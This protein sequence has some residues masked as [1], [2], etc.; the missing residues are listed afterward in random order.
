M[1]RLLAIFL[2][3]VL[4]VGYA[5]GEERRVEVRHNEWCSSVYDFP[6]ITLDWSDGSL[7]WSIGYGVKQNG[8]T[9]KE[10]MAPSRLK[11]TTSK[12][13][14]GENIRDAKVVPTGEY[15]SYYIYDSAIVDF[16]DYSVELRVSDDGVAYRFI[17]NIDE[18]FTVVN[19]LAEFSFDANDKA[20]IPYV[21][22][23]P[24]ATSDY[25]TQFETSFEN[26]YSIT[27]L[28][29]IDWRRLIFAPI[30]LE[31]KGLKFWISEANL[32]DYPGMFFSNRDQD[33]TIDTEFAPV[34]DE[35]ERGGYNMLQGMV[36]SRK[37]YIAECKGKRT[38][39]WRVVAIGKEDIDVANNTL[40]WEL[41]DECRIEDT[42]WIKPGKVAW[43]WWNDWGLEGV[44]FKPGINN[45]TYKYYIDFASRYGIEYVILD[46]G[47]SVKG[48]ADLMQVVPEI[49]IAE[50]VA[51]GEERG[52]GIILWA[53]YWALNRDIEGLCKH[54]SEMGVKGWKVDFLD[55]DDQEMVRFVYDLAEI[56][57]KY[58][59]LVD[60]HGVYKPTGL[61]YTYPNA[62]N[63]EGV[64]GLE[65]MKWLGREHDQ[66]TYD[67]TI[68]FIRN[69]AGP[70][71]YT[72]GAMRNASRANF[73]PNYS[74]PMS[75]GTR[76]HQAAMYVLYNQ[77]LAMLCDSPTAYE[78]EPEFTKILAD[79]PTDMG[80]PYLLQGEV[81]EYVVG[82]QENYNPDGDGSTDVYFAGLNGNKARSVEFQMDIS[83]IFIA[84]Y[85][86][87][88][89]DGETPTEYKHIVVP[90]EKY[91]ECRG[92]FKIDMP[93]GGG[94]VVRLN[95]HYLMGH[96]RWK[97]GG[98][99]KFI[100]DEN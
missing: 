15:D 7:R 34:P 71:D 61:Q 21:N 73:E 92:K 100:R 66:L 72:P 31:H 83:I 78:A 79:I 14:W 74:R 60:Y 28:K 26:I 52:V 62:I 49:D 82:F 94:F 8:D 88:Y 24:D 36:K 45:Q 69:A 65:T 46:E 55:R 90:L 91:S 4:S 53:G 93:A 56:A 51:Y 27:K 96:A 70:V 23:R 63:F 9:R 38:F 1:R 41:A 86:E 42:S 89:V 50:L 97:K 98:K 25:A 67:V 47:W 57:A 99:H 77:P 29:D 6:T 11:M 48:E 64:H 81:G 37:P 35:V 19:E 39:P 80:K 68:P 22:F 43:E 33:G 16:G 13:V 5:F 32:E 54:Y 12:G 17:S 58:K 84:E 59:L 10:I 18:E 3:A 95:G 20:W 40:V 87:M 30:F 85:I 2:V 76:C 75:Q 44:D